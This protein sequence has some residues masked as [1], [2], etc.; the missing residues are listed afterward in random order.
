MAVK[1][2]YGMKDWQ[3]WPRAYRL[4]DPETLEQFRDDHADELGFWGL[5]AV[6]VLTSSGGR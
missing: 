3:Q 2:Q 1:Q 5:C 4:R 6:R